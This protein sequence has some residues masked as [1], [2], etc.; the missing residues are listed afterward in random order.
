MREIDNWPGGLKHF[1]GCFQRHLAGALLVSGKLHCA[2]EL[3]RARNELING[4]A[5]HGDFLQSGI[6]SCE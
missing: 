2:V 6:A 4:A 1:K 3:D 5:A